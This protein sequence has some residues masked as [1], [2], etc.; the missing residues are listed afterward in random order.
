LYDTG[1]NRCSQYASIVLIQQAEGL[2][3]KD[4][5]G[6]SDPFAE[7][8][9]GGRLVHTT[10]IIPKSL[11]PEW[12]ENVTLYHAGL[13]PKM[14]VVIVCLCERLHGTHKHDFVMTLLLM[15]AG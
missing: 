11:C 1:E 3:A 12:N 7:I 13:S 14:E 2:L 5:G 6:T 15:P 8:L 4:L 9:L 10:K